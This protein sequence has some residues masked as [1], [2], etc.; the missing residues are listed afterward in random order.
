MR[1]VS[2]RTTQ[3]GR[4]RTPDGIDHDGNDVGHEVGA[5]LRGTDDELVDNGESSSLD[6]PLAGGL[7]LLEEDGE[8]DGSSPRGSDLNESLDGLEGGGADGGDLVG[9]RLRDDEEHDLLKEEGLDGVSDSL[10]DEDAQ[11]LASSLTGDRILLVVETLLDGGGESEALERGGSLELDEVDELSGGLLALDA[12]GGGED[13]VDVNGGRGGGGNGVSLG[14]DVGGGDLERSR[15]GD[16]GSQRHSYWHDCASGG[17]GREWRRQILRAE[18]W[19]VGSG[20][21]WEWQQR[22]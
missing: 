15:S 20:L 4:R 14:G 12:G 22:G 2:S 8:E 9:E 1:R 3:K 16:V 5:L 7:D 18:S 19:G 21:E 11:E 10:L 6:L 13:D 17:R